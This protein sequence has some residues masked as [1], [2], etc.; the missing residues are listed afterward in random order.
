MHKPTSRRAHLKVTCRLSLFLALALIVA[1]QGAR[2]A[3]GDTTQA[4][5]FAGVSLKLASETVPPGGVLQMQVFVT[6][7]K[8]ILKGSQRM[9]F[10]SRALAALPLGSMRDG[11]L[12]SPAGDVDGVAVLT[13]G[14][15]QV[16][17]S[18]PLTSFGT[19]LDSP[20][21][22][23]AIPVKS[24]A[25]SGQKVRLALDPS[26]ALWFDPSGQQ[27]LVELKAGILTVGGTTSISDV[28][29]GSGTI[30]AGS[31][32][33][34]KGTGFQPGSQVD[35]NGATVATSQFI[36]ANEIQ[37]TLAQDF[38][39][40][41]KRVRVT[42]GQERASYY[43][44]QRTRRL[45]TSTHALIAASYPMFSH[46]TW[47][48]A[49]FKPVLQ[50]S[51]F[52]GLALQNLNSSTAV[53]TAQLFSSVGVLL[54]T[55]AVSLPTNTRLVRDLVEMFPGQ[56]PGNGTTVKV[57]STVPVQ[58]LGLLG[59]DASGTVNPVE[60]SPTP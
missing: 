58:M 48:E 29:P 59:D 20:V 9:T 7:P 57:T 6:E 31:V 27:Y 17:F 4:S 56:V 15:I 49:Y 33:S 13:A 23:I 38:A 18:S 24:S 2:A 19:D 40:E 30:L 39:I 34:V 53:V 25:T 36:S 45:G 22:A 32:I 44:Y 26:A 10:S 50:G 16:F 28:V 51:M 47:A 60:P 41:G 54:A 46:T 52:S 11:E 5:A 14:S 12:F 43:P 37:I 3:S 21:I 55:R 1:S 42:T 35:V 8:P